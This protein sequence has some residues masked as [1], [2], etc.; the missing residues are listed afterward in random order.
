MISTLLTDGWTRK[1]AFIKAKGTGLMLPLNEF[2]V[3]LSPQEPAVLLKTRWDKSEAARWSLRAIDVA[4][5]YA[6]AVAVEGHDWQLTC[7]RATKDML[8]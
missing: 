7:W 3:T 8:P 5:N 1:E 2:D 6:A 4:P